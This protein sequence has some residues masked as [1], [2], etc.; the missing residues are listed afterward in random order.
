MH[1]TLCVLSLCWLSSEDF[2][3]V[4]TS[5]M[6]A[7]FIFLHR[8]FMML[9]M[10]IIE[11]LTL[12]NFIL[13]RHMIQQFPLI[14]TCAHIT[15]SVSFHVQLLIWP[16]ERKKQTYH[17]TQRNSAR[18]VERYG[19]VKYDSALQVYMEILSEESHKVWHVW[20]T[21][22]DCHILKHIQ[23][24]YC[25]FLG[26]IQ[27][28]LQFIWKYISHNNMVYPA[29]I[30]LD[31]DWGDGNVCCFICS[32]KVLMT[33][34]GKNAF[35]CLWVFLYCLLN[36]ELLGGSILNAPMPHPMSWWCTIV[37][38]TLRSKAE[39]NYLDTLQWEHGAITN[40]Y[41]Q[42][43]SYILAEMRRTMIKFWTS[44]NI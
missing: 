30:Y 20:K 6:F 41:T 25:H 38:R 27:D 23:H 28:I 42:W 17:H 31:V 4:W 36:K 40:I 10:N 9:C 39:I 13:T 8:S 12:L 16:C 34:F 44:S 3:F 32:R 2:S 5:V 14:L 7:M 37:Y 26:V 11:P 35:P 21:N 18:A 33:K 22:V 1:S 29:K 24:S 19:I 43:K 15:G